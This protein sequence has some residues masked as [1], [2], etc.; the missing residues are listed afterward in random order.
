MSVSRPCLSGEMFD[1]GQEVVGFGTGHLN[2]RTSCIA[3]RKVCVCVF[4]AVFF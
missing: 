1:L 3:E 4:K 2:S